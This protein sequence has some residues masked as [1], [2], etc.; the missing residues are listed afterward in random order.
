[1]TTAKAILLGFGL[2]ASA[3]LV[4][5]QSSGRNG[6]TVSE[7]V[8][9][10]QTIRISRSLDGRVLSATPVAAATQTQPNPTGSVVIEITNVT[11]QTAKLDI[12]DVTLWYQGG[13]QWAKIGRTTHY[14]VNQQQFTV[15]QQKNLWV[16]PGETTQVTIHYELRNRTNQKKA[17]KNTNVNLANV[18][19]TDLIFDFDDDM[20]II[21]R[22]S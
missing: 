12:S 14:T 15:S 20:K 10:G 17:H 2:L 6:R 16:Q 21:S 1:M 13:A 9:L 18:R 4:H 19:V 7:P 3:A 8:N 5:A 22:L 11:Q